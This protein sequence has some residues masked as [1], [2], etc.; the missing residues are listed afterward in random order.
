MEKRIPYRYFER[1]RR[2]QSRSQRYFTGYIKVRA[3][4]T[5][6]CLFQRHSNSER[7]IR[8][9]VTTTQREFVEVCLNQFGKILREENKFPVLARSDAN[10]ARKPDGARKN[11]PALVIV[12]LAD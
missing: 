11:E 6:P 12:L 9:S 10:P 8:P 2:A 1:R 5:I 3:T 7:V 4:K